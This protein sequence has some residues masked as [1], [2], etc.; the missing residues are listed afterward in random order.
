MIGFYYGE[1]FPLVVVNDYKLMK[2]A[3]NRTEFDGKPD[4]YAVRLR[5]PGEELRGTQLAYHLIATDL[6][7]Y[8]GIVFLLFICP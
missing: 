1:D 3:L 7:S 5:D 2:E 6:N 4:V 8:H